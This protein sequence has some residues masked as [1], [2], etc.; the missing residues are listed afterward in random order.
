MYFHGQ[1]H[2]M[3]K[4]PS[5]SI[6]SILNFDYCVETII[7]AVLLDAHISLRRRN[8]PKSFDELIEDLKNTCANLGYISEVLALH[9]LRNDVQHHSLIPSKQEV[10]RHVITVR[11]FFD[12]ICSRVYDGAITYADI[13][14]ALFIGSEV[15]KLILAEMEKA[16][17]E[18]RYSDSVYFA[19]QTVNHHVDLLHDNMK[20][21]RAWPS[22]FPRHHLGRSRAFR[23]LSEFIESTEKR[24][25]WIVDRICLREYHGDIYEFLGRPRYSPILREVADKDMAERAINITYDFITNTQDL[26]HERDLGHPYIF[27]LAILDKS[28]NECK[29]QIG[30]ADTLKIVEASLELQEIDGAEYTRKISTNIGLQT[31]KLKD[32]EKG[33]FYHLIARAKNENGKEGDNYLSFSMD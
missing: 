11:S 29:I 6:L 17:Q 7:K 26:I 3:K 24:L 1:A 27:A 33:K 20:V 32:L 12:E 9:K 4:S 15:E 2:S 10:A 23:E 18:E 22:S 19:K 21:P 14:L 8:R 30:I 31:F 25:D 16:F 13:S 28:E 5:D